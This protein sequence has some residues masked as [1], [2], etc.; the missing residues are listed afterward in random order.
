ML[1]SNLVQ[2]DP[3]SYQFNVR[4]TYAPCMLEYLRTFVESVENGRSFSGH[5][6]VLQGINNFQFNILLNIFSRVIGD[7]LRFLNIKSIYL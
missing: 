5:A 1:A 7:Y 3:V 2:F 6:V 4:T